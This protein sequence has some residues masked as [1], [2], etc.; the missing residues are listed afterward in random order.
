MR[1]IFHFPGPLPQEGTSGSRVRVGQMAEGFVRLGYDVKRIV[2]TPGERQAAFQE[3]MEEVRQG[4][5]FDFVYSESLTRPTLLSKQTIRK[6]FLDFGFFR[7]CQRQSLPI[8][9]F[10]RD[11]YW[12][13]EVYRQQTPWRTRALA[14]PLYWYDWVQYRRLVN[15]LFLPSVAM[16]EAL[17]TAWPS[18]R[19]SA[20]P[21]GCNIIDVGEENPHRASRN[22]LELFYVGG[23]A[24]PLYDLRPTL[25]AIRELNDVH[26]TLC[27]RREEWEANAHYY[28]PVDGTKTSVVHEYGKGLEPLYAQADIFVLIRNAHS[29]LDFAMPVKVFEALGYGVPLVIMEGTEAARFTEREGTGWV[30]SGAE[31]LCNCL[32]HLQ[33]NPQLIDEKRRHVE[34]V[35]M[36]HRWQD[37]AQQVADT[38]TRVPL[39]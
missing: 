8:G 11:V 22:R 4:A 3:A 34:A 19:L 35:R 20:L 27:C 32:A 26:L 13:F 15:H 28:A 37:R 30:V 16:R 9:L 39:P 10:Y 38:L 6:P 23:I 36:R 29:Y 14:L 2:G 21:P 33:A 1:M 18:E 31:E 5:T 12:R 17:P 24:P 25:A 7:W